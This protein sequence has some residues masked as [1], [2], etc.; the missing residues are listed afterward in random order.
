MGPYRSVTVG[1]AASARRGR[2]RT[3]SKTSTETRTRHRKRKKTEITDDNEGNAGRV[4]GEETDPADSARGVPP[5]SMVS[6]PILTIVT[7]SPTTSS[8]LSTRE[9]AAGKVEVYLPTGATASRLRRTTKGV[10]ERG[11]LC[12]SS[13]LLFS[14]SFSIGPTVKIFSTLTL[15]LPSDI[16]CHLRMIDSGPAAEMQFKYARDFL[17]SKTSQSRHPAPFPSS[18]SSSSSLAHFS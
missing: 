18:S 16:V 2:S 10:N 5:A 1:L 3:K 15:G 11:F 17:A 9:V 6:F 14:N 8:I 7:L 4:N 12:Q 13:F